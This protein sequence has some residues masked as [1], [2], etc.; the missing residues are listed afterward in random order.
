M[1]SINHIINIQEQQQQKQQKYEVI[2][3]V[4]L[5]MLH[6]RRQL[7]SKQKRAICFCFSLWVVDIY[8]SSDIIRQRKILGSLLMTA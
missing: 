8:F 7:L 5:Y 2:F 6:L 3:V 1:L 4:M